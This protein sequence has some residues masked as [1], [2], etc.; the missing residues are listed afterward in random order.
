M[1]GCNLKQIVI[2][3]ATFIWSI[4]VPMHSFVLRNYRKFDI[5]HDLVKALGHDTAEK[6]VR[7]LR[8]SSHSSFF[9]LSVFPPIK[10][11]FLS[12]GF[13]NWGG[14]DKKRKSDNRYF[15]ILCDE[16]TDNTK[17]EQLS[18]VFRFVNR[19]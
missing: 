12:R 1:V 16:V 6:W 2:C 5:A 19:L 14:N 10:Q 13:S 8:F 3:L 7:M 18:F 11:T 9:F 17:R 4:E 15:S